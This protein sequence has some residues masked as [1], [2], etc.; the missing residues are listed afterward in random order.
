MSKTRQIAF[1][2]LTISLLASCNF[3]SNYFKYRD[4]TKELL[5]DIIKKDYDNAVKLFALEHPS[6]EGTSPD[7]LK[8]RLPAFREI[9]VNNFGENL[10]FTMMSAEKKWSSKKEDNTP[11]NTTVVLMQF[12]NKK[13]FGIVKV[14]FDD[15]SKKVIF[16]K[17]LDVKEPV[18]N[19]TI[20]W[21]F[22]LLAIS[23]VIFN[24][25]VLRQIK[26]SNL[27]KKWI[28]YLAVIFINVPAITFTPVEGLSY[29]LFTFQF[30]LG[31]SFSFMGYLNTAWTFG[32]PLGGLY[33]IW[34]LRQKNEEI[35]VTEIST[36]ENIEL[37]TDN[38]N[39]TTE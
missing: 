11:P 21:L 32:V 35:I 27:K 38:N 5:N 28:K 18:P 15:N 36:D 16:I 23:V 13:E 34:K 31:I 37:T 22:G 25:Y 29:S 14:W 6:F 26:R 9:L 8:A 20:F 33:W 3:A 24:I 7:T 19:M 2:I 4:T 30:M 12:A 10:D 17:T 39:S 1:T